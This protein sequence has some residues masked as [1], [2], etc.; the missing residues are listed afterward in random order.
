MI[1]SSNERPLKKRLKSFNLAAS[2]LIA[3]FLTS[4]AAEDSFF[5]AYPSDISANEVIDFQTKSAYHFELTAPQRCASLDPVAKNPRKISCQ[6]PSIGKKDVSLSVCD[7]AK[8]FCKPVTFSV[9][10]VGVSRPQKRPL[11]PS[12]A[13]RV[14]QTEIKQKTLPGFE[15]ISPEAVLKAPEKMPVFVMISTDWCPPCNEA[16]EN[17][18]STTAFQDVTRAWRRVYVDGDSPDSKFWQAYAPFAFYPS[19]ILLSA[20]LKEID[21]FG[22]PTRLREFQTWQNEVRPHINVPIQDV[23]EKFIARQGHSLKQ[24]ALDWL[25]DTNKEKEKQRLIDWAL[26]SGDRE[27]LKLFTEADVPKVSRGKWYAAELAK[28][29]SPTDEERNRLMAKVVE[30][31][32]NT[33]SFTGDLSDLCEASVEECKKFVPDLGGRYEWW[34]H[35]GFSSALEKETA[36]ALEAFLQSEIYSA[37]GD[38]AKAKDQA[39][40]CVQAAEAEAK[41]SPLGL[42]R[43]A[44]IYRSRCL[45]QVGRV[46]DA[47][48]LYEDLIKT[49]GNEPTFQLRYAG[50][51]KRQK[52]FKDAKVWAERSLKKSYGY[53]WAAA[54]N[55]KA[56]MEIQLK[57]F[58]A[59][60]KTINEAISELDLS[61]SNPSD[62]DQIWAKRFRETEKRI[63]LK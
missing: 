17:L 20:D 4:A 45:E 31:N 38:K 61:S 30:A 22:G 48:K 9:N 35:Q 18:L 42:P 29:E 11:A 16:K 15:H 55:L 39:S 44:N 1:A 60:Q 54:V 14:S 21:R 8:T 7:N 52:R 33:E 6:F 58:K 47:E 53:N 57:D 28:L 27:T 63:A 56:D 5:K 49:Y 34:N 19:F 51:L 59:A 43:A 10:V 37:V 32:K 26:L 23:K 40:I 3:C 62:R 46:K 2:A 36:L 13:L 25:N 41:G 12:D 24:W 50:F